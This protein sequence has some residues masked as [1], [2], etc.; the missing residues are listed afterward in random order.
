[1][2]LPQPDIWLGCCIVAHTSRLKSWCTGASRPGSLGEWLIPPSPRLQ[3]SGPLL[4][5]HDPL[6]CCFILSPLRYVN[7]K[8]CHSKITKLCCCIKSFVPKDFQA[9]VCTNPLNWI[10]FKNWTHVTLKR[11][12]TS[13]PF[14]L[15]LTFF[16]WNKI[17]LAFSLKHTKIWQVQFS[18]AQNHG[19]T[20]PYP[21]IT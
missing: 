20:K 3:S 18:L 1:M 9:G 17:C 21:G 11:S 14:S 12:N 10:Q 19:V 13:T 6:L 16:Q 4:I 15:L 2:M 7:H 5:S 8:L